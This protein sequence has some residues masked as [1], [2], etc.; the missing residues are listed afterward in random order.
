MK[1]EVHFI[2]VGD[3]RSPH[4][5]TLPMKMYQAVRIAEEVMILSERATLLRIYIYIYSLSYLTLQ[6]RTTYEDIAQ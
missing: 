3:F 4:K 1:T 2:V 6:L 5:R